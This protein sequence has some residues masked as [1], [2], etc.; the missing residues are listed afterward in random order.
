MDR[1]SQDGGRQ[2]PIRSPSAIMIRGD[3]E[4][5]EAGKGGQAALPEIVRQV[6]D[7]NQQPYVT[8]LRRALFFWLRI[9]I[10]EC[11]AGEKT[12]AV[13]VRIPI[14]LPLIGAFFRHKLSWSQAFRFIEQGRRPQGIPPS[15]FLDSCM[16]VE[17]LRINEKK[18]DKEELV[19]IGSD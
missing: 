8:F 19:V 15:C 13:D 5:A 7:G 6:R 4:L 18:S 14:P 12:S 10:C 3:G 17:F 16:A 2:L 1:A 11:K 9:Y